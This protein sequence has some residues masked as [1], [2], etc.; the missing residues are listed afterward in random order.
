M[1]QILV[2][3]SNFMWPLA[4]Y[5]DTA[6]VLTFFGRGI[7]LDQPKKENRRKTKRDI[8][9]PFGRLKR[10]L[11]LMT[12]GSKTMECTGRS[13][14]GLLIMKKARSDQRRSAGQVVR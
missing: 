10:F 1:F 12:V 13:T 4:T 14:T 3:K 6:A 8:I 2:Q 9:S 11:V 5:I 7:C